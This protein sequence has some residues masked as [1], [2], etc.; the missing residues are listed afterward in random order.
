MQLRV[1][2]HIYAIHYRTT[3]ISVRNM[4]CRLL[5][6]H[7]LA[8]CQ[9][10]LLVISMVLTLY[11]ALFHREVDGELVALL[12]GT[13]QLEVATWLHALQSLTVQTDGWILA[14]GWNTEVH[15]LAGTLVDGQLDGLVGRIV[16]GDGE[17]EVLAV[18]VGVHILIDIEFL[19]FLSI[20]ECRE[21]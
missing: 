10:M 20:E 4:L 8:A 13:V 18:I 11:P 16:A 19:A 14:P 6:I 15:L 12:P 9:I 2:N 7:N 17:L 1:P 21:Q 5:I 3:E